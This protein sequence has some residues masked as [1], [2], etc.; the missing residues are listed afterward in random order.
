ML[1]RIF[2]D[3]NNRQ[4]WDIFWIGIIQ[5]ANYMFPFVTTGYLLR[6]LGLEYL[7]RLEFAT[8]LILYF[9]TLVNYEYH[10]SGTRDLSRIKHNHNEVSHEVSVLITTK[11]YLFV[12]ST[13][14]FLVIQLLWPDRFR[15]AL[16]NASY[17]IV[18]GHL[19]Y[20]PYVFL[21]LNKVRVL[22]VLNFLLK[23]L[24]TLLIFVSVKSPESYVSVNLNYSISQILIGIL[25]MVL[26]QHYFKLK[27]CWKPFGEVWKSLK[28]GLYIFLTNGVMAQLS[29]NLIQ[30]LMGLY[31]LPEILGSYTSVLKVVIAIHVLSMMPLKQVF[32]PE[33]AS[34]WAK[35]RKDYLK[36]FKT[37]TTL[38]LAGNILAAATLFIFA[39][40]IIR[41]Y[42]GDYIEPMIEILRWLAYVPLVMGLTN[43]YIFDGLIAMG[44]DKLVFRLQVGI[45]IPYI[46][47]LML[48]VP[49][50][51]LIAALVIRLSVEVLNLIIG[52]IY[53]YR[54]LRKVPLE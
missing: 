43:A 30:L 29:L 42:A 4:K 54:N 52:M 6:T 1:G 34:L 48:L 3:L 2:K 36:K 7:G 46:V 14:L 32:F 27:L 26:I 39:P 28:R 10:I 35:N 9:V 53:Y 18:V 44:K 50:Y 25:S 12:L 20:Q 17:L 45:T 38:L 23:A 21:S 41:I 13:I 40:T 33:L 47:L 49:R 51:G 8:Y 24:S 5:V 15:N 37:Y 19:L 16:F 31:L 22:A 11:S